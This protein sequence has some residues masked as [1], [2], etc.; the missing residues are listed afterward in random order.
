MRESV[1]FVPCPHSIRQVGID[2][3]IVP[4]APRNHIVIIRIVGLLPCLQ[5]LQEIHVAAACFDH[6]RNLFGVAL[7][8]PGAPYGPALAHAA[9]VGIA[10]RLKKE[11]LRLAVGAHPP[12]RL[13]VERMGI[14]GPAGIGPRHHVFHPLLR[15]HR[16]DPPRHA[17]DIHLLDGFRR[18]AGEL[19]HLPA[20]PEELEELLVGA[21]AGIGVQ[22]AGIQTEPT[23]LDGF[24]YV[25]LLIG[26][27]Q[28]PPAF[29]R[30]GDLRVPAVA[31]AFGVVLRGF[32]QLNAFIDIPPVEDLHI[33]LRIGI[34]DIHVRMRVNIH[35]P[36]PH[37]WYLK[38]T[39]YGFRT[40]P[41][42]NC[43][44]CLLRN[45]YSGRKQ[46]R[47]LCTPPVKCR[48]RDGLPLPVG[49]HLHLR[50]T[51]QA[52][53]CEFHQDLASGS[54]VGPQFIYRLRNAFQPRWLADGRSA[55]KQ[56]QQKKV[57]VFHVQVQ[58]LA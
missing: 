9:A 39:F 38:R 28:Q 1:R 49:L 8:E 30:P 48:K 40:L 43:N 58:F 11:H 21:G 7:A 22:V 44:L 20:E 19:L 34:A 15:H 10:A 12:E 5:C 31:R 6:R 57:Q 50:R 35:G 24:H 52:A 2:R 13:L 26:G 56:Q 3:G 55:K 53:A 25:G 33:G 17:G 36:L 14:A 32:G 47:Q 16:N 18:H 41:Y 27:G 54:A 51:H 4:Q 23:L 45:R 46:N 37:R 29:Q 42:G